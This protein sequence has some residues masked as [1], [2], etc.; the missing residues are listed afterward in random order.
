ME[1]Y[2]LVSKDS[3]FDLYPFRGRLCSLFF[4]IAPQ[5]P[6]NFQYPPKGS[7]KL[8]AG[9][10]KLPFA[11]QTDTSGGVLTKSPL[12]VVDTEVAI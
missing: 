5:Y 1:N 8:E 7:W 4:Y 12:G 3:L 2:V 9:S 11:L 6:G 10:W